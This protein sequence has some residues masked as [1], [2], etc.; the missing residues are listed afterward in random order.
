VFSDFPTLKLVISHGGG[1]IPYQVG[2]FRAAGGRRGAKERFED[3]LRRL[4]FDTCLY[5]REALELLF[6]VVGPDRCMFG[7]E[8]PGTGTFRDPETGR[9]MDDL[10][11]IIESISWLTPEDRKK[12]FEDTARKIYKL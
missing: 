9:Y 3:G 5:S 12:I 6:K 8:A 11:P 10:K 1:A 2:R 7:T 4:Y